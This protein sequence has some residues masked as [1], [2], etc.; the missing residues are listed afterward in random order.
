MGHVDF[1]MG[2]WYPKLGM[3]QVPLSL[4][5]LAKSLGVKFTYGLPVTKINIEN[6]KATGLKTNKEFIPADII[7]SN[8]DYHFAETNLL[9]PSYQTYP[10]SYWQKRILAPSGFVMYLGLSRQLNALE[11][12]N[13]MFT[14][15]WEAHFDSIFSKN[16]SWYKRPSYY[17]SVTSRTDPSA[18]PKGKENVFVLV[19]IASGLKDTQKHRDDYKNLVYADLE[20]VTGQDVRS[21]VEYEKI[22]TIQDYESEY[23]SYKGTALGLAHSLTQ[24]AMF[25]PSNKSKKVK[26]LYY[27]GQNTVP[28]IGVPTCLI[29]GQAVSRRIQKDLK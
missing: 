9:D 13:L 5:K 10:E 4:E 23:N 2:V 7:V 25:R 19:P 6:G 24:S 28:G 26:N 12:H 1:N 18:A 3:H 21:L 14:N 29:S 11:H 8:A 22:F 16:T 20:K 17:V 15:D 27:C